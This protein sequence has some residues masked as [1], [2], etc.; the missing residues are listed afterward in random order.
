MLWSKLLPKHTWIEIK[1]VQESVSVV[2]KSCEVK[3]KKK[4][5]MSHGMYHS[6]H[7]LQKLQ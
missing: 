4:N 3:K 5:T 2:D 1:S 7:D 6:D